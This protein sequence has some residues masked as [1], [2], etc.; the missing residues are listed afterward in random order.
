MRAAPT[1]AARTASLLSRAAARP[2]LLALAGY[3]VVVTAVTWPLAARLGRDTYG[4]P[5]DGWALIWQTRE[6]F[7][8]GPSY[9]SP[10]VYPDIARP[11]GTEV[12]SGILLSN[13]VTELPNMLLLALGVGDV[14]A[15]NLMTLA[16]GVASATTMFLVLRRLG[17]SPPAAFWG[18]M[19]L[20]IAP[21]E[22]DRLAIHLTLA[23]LVAL[24]LLLLGTV[25]WIRR[26]GLRSGALLG[27]AVA[28]ALYTH[29][30]YGLMAAIALVIALPLA[31]V[32]ARRRG[33]LREMAVRSAALAG[34][35]A[36]VALPLAAALVAQSSAVTR[37]LNRPL[38]L[39]DLVLEPHLL[40]L[41]SVHNPVFGGAVGDYLAEGALSPN[42]GEL[43]LY[44]GWATIALALVGIAAA[45][46]GRAPRLPVAVATSW[47]LV[48]LLLSLPAVVDL[49]L[50]GPTSMPIAYLQDLTTVISTPARFFVMT[51]VGAVALAA[52]GLQALRGVTGARVWGALVG[53]AVVVSLVELPTDPGARVVDARSRPALVQAIIDTVPPGA[54]VAQY[55]LT[56]RSL[57]VVADQLYW[58]TVHG[59]PLLNG[60]ASQSFEDAVRR[61]VAVPGDPRTPGLLA[62]LGIRW[63]TLDASAFSNFPG[64]WSEA[65]IPRSGVSGRPALPDGSRVLRVTAPPAPGIVALWEGFSI[66]G[67][68]VHS[69]WLE[70]ERGSLVVCATR[71]GRHRLTVSGVAFAQPRTLRVGDGSLTVPVRES[72]T[73][74]SVSLRLEAGW[75]RLPIRL[76]GSRPMRPSDLVPGSTDTRLLSVALGRPRLQGPSGGDPGTCRTRPDDSVIAS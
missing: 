63:M 7:D 44:L 1:P 56:D 71:P 76:T 48:G 50:V 13:I 19:A 40:A 33:R 65:S 59:R 34:A 39:T 11:F 29:V 47:A 43:A 20:L 30:Y 66:E 15:Y 12:P 52:L 3:L 57:R 22:L 60:A 61:E 31:L 55:P 8:S 72:A 27:T 37:Q 73:D 24:P 6:R 53:L 38:Y 68:S 42:T 21:W 58:Q 9:F 18:G 17:V 70:A 2:A 32:A 45:I 62:L 64:G 35:L 25:E 36:L 54:P 5:G 26:P 46:A 14:P 69:R 23:T 16:A 4:G 74:V 28:I 75:Q 67:P 51:L 49:P 41:P 10:G